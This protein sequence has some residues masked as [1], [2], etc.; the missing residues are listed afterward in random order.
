MVVRDVLKASDCSGNESLSSALVKAE[1][2]LTQQDSDDL[3]SFRRRSLGVSVA[4]C[5]LFN[6]PSVTAVMK[7]RR[8][9]H[10]ER[11][12]RDWVSNTGKSNHPTPQCLVSSW[13]TEDLHRYS[14]QRG[15]LNYST[16]KSLKL[17]NKQEQL[18]Q[19]FNRGFFKC[20]PA[21]RLAQIRETF[22]K[23]VTGQSQWLPFRIRSFIIIGLCPKEEQSARCCC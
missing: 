16:N 7:W 19:S 13:L 3:T 15:C 20:F 4:D 8:L 14:S 5:M 12:H 9:S 1:S 11:H 2:K 6:V 10:S 18:Q 17:K 22:I 21:R 23:L